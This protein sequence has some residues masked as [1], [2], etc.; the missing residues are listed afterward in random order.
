MQDKIIFIIIGGALFAA[1]F[2]F[3]VIKILVKN[4]K[5]KKTGVLNQ[6]LEV[7]KLKSDIVL[8]SI[9]DGVIVADA[10]KVIGVSN[11]GPGGRPV[12]QFSAAFFLDKKVFFPLFNKKNEGLKIRPS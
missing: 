7:E 9:E 6:K 3:I 10:N 12:W 1:L 2:L 11:R 5:T 4:R 8:N